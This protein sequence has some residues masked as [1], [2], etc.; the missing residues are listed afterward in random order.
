MPESQSTIASSDGALNEFQAAELIGQ[1]G[2]PPRREVPA[3]PRDSEGKFMSE[4]PNK[5]ADGVIEDGDL[6]NR[7]QQRVREDD[8]AAEIDGRFQDDAPSQDDPNG[9]PAEGE[10]DIDVTEEGREPDEAE[11]QA[12][13]LDM[14]ASWGKTAAELWSTL[15]PEHQQFLHQHEAK[16]TAGI[17]RQTQELQSAK[18]Q[19]AEQTQAIE[20]ERLNLAN[21]ALRLQADAV[22]QFQAE[23]KDADPAQLATHDPLKFQRYQA[24]LI[25]V[26]Q[27]TEEA[28]A[29]QAAVDDHRA[30]QLATFRKAE[31][32]K[33]IEKMP[34]LA[35]QAKAQ[36]FE[37]RISEGL[38]NLGITPQRLAQYNAEEVSL[39]ND[40]LKWRAAVAKRQ[41]AER[42][43][44]EG[45]KP[46]R[47]LKPGAPGQ[48]SSVSG[49][50]RETQL[51]QNLRKTG[52]TE[53]AA[54]LLKHRAQRR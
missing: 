19:I 26:N 49:Q 6:P 7:G 13:S 35:D 50:A 28:R 8:A 31:N 12:P 34:E 17:T 43:Q 5:I 53:A 37:R 9:A 46:P 30:N 52:S 32:E 36:A 3:T 40:G 33:L 47:V 38:G 20:N 39:V 10:I 29:W 11:P 48:S 18:D 16:R 45:A 2:K 23:F 27:A 42:Q 15:S 21:A 4:R 41:A 44:R 22:R 54:A 51:K 1:L 14:P 25:K 24:A